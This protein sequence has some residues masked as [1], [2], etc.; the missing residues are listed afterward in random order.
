MGANGID[1]NNDGDLDVTVAGVENFRVES[2]SA[3]QD[4]INA[5]GTTITGAAFP[6]A[7]RIRHPG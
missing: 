1:L 2:D 3:G 5:G 4:V 6:T 7:R